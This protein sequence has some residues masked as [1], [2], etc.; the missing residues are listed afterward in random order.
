[1]S[2]YRAEYE[3]WLNAYIGDAKEVDI[4]YLQLTPDNID[5]LK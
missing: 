4:P 5:K 2:N 3:K 1:M